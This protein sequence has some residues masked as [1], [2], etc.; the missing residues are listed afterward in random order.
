MNAWPRCACIGYQATVIASPY[1]ALAD[2]GDGRVRRWG[3]LRDW[4]ERGQSE[5]K[6]QLIA[7]EVPSRWIPLEPS[8]GNDHLRVPN[9]SNPYNS[10]PRQSTMFRIATGLQKNYIQI[11]PRRL[12]VVHTFARRESTTQSSDDDAGRT[13]SI[14][15]TSHKSWGRCN[16]KGKVNYSRLVCYCIELRSTNSSV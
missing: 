12:A 1:L 13:Q 14:V 6:F 7:Y 8:E 16:V 11:L 10:F 15:N 9:S 5:F 4:A 3:L 2:A